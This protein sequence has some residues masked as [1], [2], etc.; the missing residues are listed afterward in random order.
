MLSTS[1]AYPQ[2]G[3]TLIELM[4]AIAILGLLLGLGVPS[5]G[6]WIQNTQIR[7]AAE[8]VQN[9][10]NLARAE[11]VRRNIAVKFTLGTGSSWTVAL[12]SAGT[13]IQ[14]NPNSEGASNATVTATPAGATTATFNGLGRIIANADGSAIVTQLDFAVPT[15][16]LSASEQRELRIT[17]DTPG[18]SIRMCD[19]DPSVSSGDPRKC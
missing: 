6:A 18:G 7:N 11:A 17:I 12:S 1:P 14:S 8:S 3:V 9:G 4:I 16:I 2:R 10:L 19:P 15:T 13:S 5:F